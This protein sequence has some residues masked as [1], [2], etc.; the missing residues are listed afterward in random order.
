MDKQHT[1]TQT[2]LD[3]YSQLIKERESGQSRTNQE[4]LQLSERIEQARHDV[5][6]EGERWQ[7]MTEGY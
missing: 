6:I 3:R 7:Y 5:E 1:H 2:A 4:E